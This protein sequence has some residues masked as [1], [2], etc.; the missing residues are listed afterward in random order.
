MTLNNDCVD[1]LRSLQAAAAVGPTLLRQPGN[2]TNNPQ[3]MPG[4]S[5]NNTNY[6][7]GID[8][9]DRIL[10]RQQVYQEDLWVQEPFPDDMMQS[11]PEFYG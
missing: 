10:F 9:E 2:S 7:S 1:R 8:H 11:S 5:S 4:P 6:M 3:Q